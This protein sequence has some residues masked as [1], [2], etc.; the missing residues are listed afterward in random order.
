VCVSDSRRCHGRWWLESTSS[1][2]LPPTG[3]FGGQDGGGVR[4]PSP[5]EVN[6]TNPASTIINITDLVESALG[7]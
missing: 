6:M 2:D 5:S 3:T 4:R 7:F 1:E